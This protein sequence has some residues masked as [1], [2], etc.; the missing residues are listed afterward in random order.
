MIQINNL[1]KSYYLN[2][3][4]IPILKDIS[5]TL[6]DGEFVALTGQSGSGK[7]T[8]VPMRESISSGGD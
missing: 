7:S 4:A 3:I 5:L 6:D 8:L 2:G 1:H